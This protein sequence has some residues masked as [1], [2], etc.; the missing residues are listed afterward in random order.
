MLFGL[1]TMTLV[2]QQNHALL[3]P[4]ELGHVWENF[5]GSESFQDARKM[6]HTFVSFLDEP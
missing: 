1:D 2:V 5:H 3:H 6:L 4:T